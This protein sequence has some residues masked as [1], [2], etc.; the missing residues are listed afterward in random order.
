[1]RQRGAF[2]HLWLLSILLFHRTVA[3][4]PWQGGIRKELSMNTKFTKVGGSGKDKNHYW[5]FSTSSKENKES[6]V[7][8]DVCGLEYRTQDRLM[9]HMYV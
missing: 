8:C 1:M 2:Q 3:A 9:R 7:R 4:N 6:N 5:T